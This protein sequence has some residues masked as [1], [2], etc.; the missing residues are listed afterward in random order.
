MTLDE[1]ARRTDTNNP[2]RF[3]IDPLISLARKLSHRLS[4]PLPFRGR[5]RVA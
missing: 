3:R 4:V 1:V 5:T 2:L